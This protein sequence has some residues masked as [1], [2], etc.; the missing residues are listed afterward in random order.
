MPHH[1]LVPA[2][3]SIDTERSYACSTA[4]VQCCSVRV[5]GCNA[6][7]S[8]G[9]ELHQYGRFPAAAAQ[10][11]IPSLEVCGNYFYVRETKE[12]PVAT[13]CRKP[14]ALDL[15]GGESHCTNKG[16]VI[17]SLLLRSA[18]ESRDVDCPSWTDGGRYIDTF[19]SWWNSR[20]QGLQEPGNTS[21]LA[22]IIVADVLPIL[23][24]QG[25]LGTN[26]R[27]SQLE[28]LPLEVLYSAPAVYLSAR[29]L[30]GITV[31]PTPAV[32]M[33]AT[34][35]RFRLSA[36]DDN[37][38]RYNH[39]LGVENTDFHWGGG[40]IR[41]ADPDHI[42]NRNVK[43][44]E[45]DWASPLFYLPYMA[46]SKSGHQWPTYDTTG[47][48]GQKSPRGEHPSLCIRSPRNSHLAFYDLPASTLYASSPAHNTRP[49]LDM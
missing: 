37:D 44:R 16:G 28:F 2:T 26:W 12:G 15:G 24:G 40:D 20:R 21:T 4:N 29:E 5:D 27:H 30:Y 13:R 43:A 32:E 47:P 9:K 46:D 7:R 34:S 36:P 17:K 38:F 1:P 23:K 48:L 14:P 39:N 41:Y 25:A 33:Y 11:S 19:L 35:G 10:F 31:P 49:T 6:L 8:D 3:V 22:P 42:A 45:V 18:G